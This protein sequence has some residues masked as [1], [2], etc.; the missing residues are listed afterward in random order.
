[1]GVMLVVKGKWLV[2]GDVRILHSGQLDFLLQFHH[3]FPEEAVGVHEILDRLAG[4]DHCGMIPAAEVLADR[5]EGLF[6]EGFGQVHSDLSRLNDLAF[7]G[8]LQQF[9]IGNIEILTDHTLYSFDSYLLTASFHEITEYLF[10]QFKVYFPLIKRR[11]CQKGDQSAFQLTYVA[12][13]II[14][15]IFNYFFWHFEPVVLHLPLENIDPR[16]IVR[17]LQVCTESPAEAAQ[18]SFLQAVQILGWLVGRKDQLLTGLMKMIEDGKEGILGFL[19][20]VE[21]LDVV[22][23]QDVHQLIEMDEIVDGIVAAMVDEL[24]DEFFGTHIQYDFVL[25]QALDLVAYGLC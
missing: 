9:I 3:I 10:C 11:L 18:Q 8:F 5:L 13:D 4:V 20:P 7:A 24:V 23:D 17:D 1:M 6:G 16:I 15:Q 25:M 19:S 22:D 14:S 21:E 12:V 2:I